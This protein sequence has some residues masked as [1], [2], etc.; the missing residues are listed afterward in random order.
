MSLLKNLINRK[1]TV[2]TPL[3]WK[4]N[5]EGPDVKLAYISEGEAEMLAHRDNMMN[6]GRGRQYGPR[7]IPAFPPGPGGNAGLGGIGAG[8]GAALPVSHPT[9]YRAERRQSATAP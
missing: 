8:I 3:S 1:K 9:I 4:R 6:P 5:D 2:T 7:G